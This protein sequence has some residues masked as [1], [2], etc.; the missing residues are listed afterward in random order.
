MAKAEPG[1]LYLTRDLVGKPT[2]LELK[3][4]VSI[5]V[6]GSLNEKDTVA[7]LTPQT[8]VLTED[9]EYPLNGLPRYVAFIGTADR[10]NVEGYGLTY[11]KDIS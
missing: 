2:L 7:D 4:N 5:Q 1:K 9:E 8:Y 6:F 10:I 11:V 3:G